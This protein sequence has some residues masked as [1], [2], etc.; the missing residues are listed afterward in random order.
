MNPHTPPPFKPAVLITGGN[1]LVGRYLTSTLISA[2]YNVSIL[3]R[4]P[5]DSDKVRVFE[6]NPE[7]KIIDPGA[8]DGVDYLIHLAGSNIGK[9]GGP[10]EERKR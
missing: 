1:G 2:G 8:L 7:K 5:T 4:N 10:K 6:W 3:S 9:K